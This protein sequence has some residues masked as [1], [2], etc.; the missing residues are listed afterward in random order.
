MDGRVQIPVIEWIRAETGAEHVDMITEPGVDGVVANDTH[1]ISQ[2]VS[3]IKLSIE[4][5]NA[6]AVFIAGHH[7]CKGNPVDDETHKIHI[8]ASVERIKKEIAGPPVRGLWVD[9]D[10]NTNPL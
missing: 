8:K 6:S 4:A 2:L 3:K 10:W 7:D 9:Q 1:D 5:N